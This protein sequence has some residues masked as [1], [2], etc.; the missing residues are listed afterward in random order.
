MK[1][2]IAFIFICLTS[3]FGV[4]PHKTGKEG[5][6]FPEFDILL[7]DSTTRLNTRSIVAGKPIALFYFSPYCPYCMAQT[8][9][10]IEEMD[11]LKDIQFYFVTIF[12]PS[13]LK[14]FNKRYQLAKYPNITVGVDPKQF[15]RNYFEITGIPFMAIYGK[16]K[17][18]NNAFR[19]EITAAQLKKVA[20]E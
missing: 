19:G 8:K 6:S 5:K 7:T 13:T 15:I 1:Q 14:D 10:I 18:L 9:E 16:E 2:F 4:E 11:E 20:D 17:K 12:P 3:C